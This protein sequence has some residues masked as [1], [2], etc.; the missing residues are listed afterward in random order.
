MKIGSKLAITF[1]L[2][3]FLSMMVIGF[4]SYFRAKHALQ[5]QSFDKLTAFRELKAGQIEDYF[6]LIND[7]IITM[8]ESPTVIEA[9]KEFEN[10]Y[11]AIENEIKYSDEE[12]EIIK[13]RGDEYISR[14]FLPRLNKNIYPSAALQDEVAYNKTSVILTDL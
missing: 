7:Q 6:Q 5:K 4:I 1:F 14:E 10:G 2:I 13:K 11:N 3:A 8:A 9:M 12:F